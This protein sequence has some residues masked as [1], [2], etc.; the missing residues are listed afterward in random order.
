M[1]FVG[2]GR[3]ATNT[4]LAAC[5][6]AFTAMA[7][8]YAMSKKWDISYTVNGFLAG[9]VA[10][11]CPC[12]WVSPTGSIL[13]G[14]IAGFV[15]VAGVE[16]LEY[17]RIDDP[18]GAWPVHGLCGVWGT[19]SLGFFAAGK[20]GA[21]GPFAPDNSAPLT[22]LFYG[23]GT[24]LLVAQAIGSGVTTIATFGVALVVML[25]VNAFGLLR[26]DAEGE[27]YGMDLT[28]HGI[29]AYPEYVISAAGR[30]TG[31][32]HFDESVAAVAQPVGKP[33][34]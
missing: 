34:R 26:L 33:A 7:V 28:E 8:A 27:G 14:G 20:Y 21:T 13:L 29:P 17:L 19:L 31:M 11:T 15:V 18:I 3:V 10:I 32:I 4:T 22:G 9:L 23:G 24:Q 6:A 16:L 25:A 2:I 30:P 5:A 12:Y 1:D